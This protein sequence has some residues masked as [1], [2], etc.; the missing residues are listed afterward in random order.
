[1]IWHINTGL[2]VWTQEPSQEMHWDKTHL[3][4]NFKPAPTYATMLEQKS[5]STILQGMR[6]EKGS[7]GFHHV[8][9]SVIP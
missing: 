5:I 9:V 4:L 6:H 2:E 8:R 7:A 1:M 3:N